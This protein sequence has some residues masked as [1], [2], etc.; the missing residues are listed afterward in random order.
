MT[1]SIYKR[2]AVV[3]MGIALFTACSDDFLDRQPLDQRVE[4]NFYQTQS[5]AEEAL[6][7]IFDV[8]TWNTVIGFHPLP[9]FSDIASDD[10]Y[11]GGASR[12]DAPNIIEVDKFNIR[13]TSGEV[14]GMW[15]KYYTGIYRANLYLEKI[16]GIEASEDFV[17]RTTAEARFLRAYWYFDLL[18]VFERVPLLTSTLK[19]PSEYQ[20]PQAEPEAIYNQIVT[21]LIAAMEDLPETVP[22]TENGRPSTW[23]ARALLGRVQLYVNGVYGENPTAQ[24]GTVVDAAYALAR[25]EEVINNSGHDLME[26]YA[27]IFARSGEFG[28]ESVWEISYSDARPWY[29]WGYIQGGE[30]N[31]AVQMQGPRVDNP[32]QEI[33]DRGWSFAPVTQE[34]YDAFEEGDPRRDLTIL[35]DSEINAGLSIGYQH[36]GYF[37][38]KYTTSKEYAPS[39]GQPELNWGNNYRDIRFADVLLMAAELGSPNAQGYLDRVRA[40]VGLASVPATLEN[41]MQERR[42]ELALEGHRYWDLLRQGTA[43]AA[44]AINVDGPTGDGYQGDDQDFQVTFDETRRGLFPIPQTEIDISNGLYSQNPGY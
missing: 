27:D 24:D 8:L 28:V 10:A 14:Q 9:M 19:A 38:Q 33:V 15:R 1:L 3:L 29:D 4:S 22:A 43:A 31:I 5:D 42:V 30:G 6:V 44:A 37:T 25:L 34:L 13:T 40:R 20:Q 16:Q 39:D 21:D 11:A 36:T 12:N 26:N 17:I 18:R 7:A 2:A 35:E 23:A 32:G 41:I